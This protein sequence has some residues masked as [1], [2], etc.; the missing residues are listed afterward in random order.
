[1]HSNPDQMHAT[2]D[3]M[4][5]KADEFWEDIET[6]RMEA[7]ALMSADWVGEAADTHA[8]LWTEWVESA[9]KVAVALREDAMLV[10][11][12]ADRYTETD[13]KNASDVT[14]VQFDLGET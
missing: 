10:H 9:R 6:L 13:S 11:Q 4:S 2:A 12:S 1:M 7:D 14:Y 8:A 3:R 5:S